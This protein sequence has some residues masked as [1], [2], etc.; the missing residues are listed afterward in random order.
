MVAATVVLLTALILA[1]MA[2]AARAAALAPSEA[3]RTD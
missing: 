3:L 1:T 2:P